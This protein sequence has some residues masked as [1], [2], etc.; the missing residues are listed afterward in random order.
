MRLLSDLLLASINNMSH[1]DW[2]AALEVLVKQ[3]AFGL[4]KSTFVL[5]PACLSAV[6][7]RVSVNAARGSRL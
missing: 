4:A 3:T 7:Q 1:C 2:S 6:A 5:D